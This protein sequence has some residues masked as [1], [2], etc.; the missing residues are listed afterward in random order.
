VEEWGEWLS[1]YLVKCQQV[2]DTVL[3]PRE[4]TSGDAPAYKTPKKLARQQRAAVREV[5]N[6]EA[7]NSRC[8]NALARSPHTSTE[9]AANRD[10]D[11]LIASL[12]EDRRTTILDSP[13]TL[14]EGLRTETLNA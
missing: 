9:F 4:Y 12:P 1:N 8:K 14:L 7:L 2:A 11:G 13:D 5:A 6:W 10:L 3:Q